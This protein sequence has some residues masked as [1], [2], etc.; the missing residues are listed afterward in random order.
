MITPADRGAGMDLMVGLR[1]LGLERYG[2]AF[3]D[4]EIDEYR[5][6]ELDRR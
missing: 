6:S 5:S 4:N 3:R 2:A 1:S